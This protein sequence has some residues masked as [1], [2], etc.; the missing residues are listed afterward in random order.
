ME[1][2]SFTNGRMLTVLAW[3]AESPRSDIA[4]KRWAIEQAMIIRGIGQPKKQKVA[5]PPRRPKV[6]DLLGG[7]ATNTSK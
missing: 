2:R 1:P 3:I 5:K 7:S 6:I 4:T